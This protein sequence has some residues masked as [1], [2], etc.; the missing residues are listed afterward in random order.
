MNNETATLGSA[1]VTA[2]TGVR[3]DGPNSRHGGNGAVGRL[4]L[5]YS[6]SYTGTTTPTLNVRLD[7]SIVPSMNGGGFLFNLL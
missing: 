6:K 2:A 5:D 1:K 7:P 3:G 4:N